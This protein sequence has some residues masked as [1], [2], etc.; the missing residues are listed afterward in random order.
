MAHNLCYTTLVPPDQVPT[1]DPSQ[2]TKSPNGFSFV[3]KETRRGL[4]PMILE[5]LLAARKKAKKA[6]AEAEDPLTKSVLN[7]RQLA[8]KISANSVYG[9]TGAT[10]GVLPCLEISSSVTA[11]GRAMIDHTKSLVEAEYTVQKGQAHDAQVIYGDTDSVM[12]RFGTESVEE[13]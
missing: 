1:V 9:F 2:V 10:V 8:L 5:E 13:A 6:M 11:F 12:V 7:G 4:L 3:H